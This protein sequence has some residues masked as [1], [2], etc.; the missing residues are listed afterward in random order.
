MMPPIIIFCAVPMSHGFDLTNVPVFALALAGLRFYTDHL[1]CH[2]L[3]TSKT[4]FAD[5]FYHDL[6]CIAFDREHPH[7]SDATVEAVHNV[8]DQHIRYHASPAATAG[9][10]G[11]SWLAWAGGENRLGSLLV[12]LSG[13]PEALAT[14]ALR[15]AFYC[16]DDALSH[17]LTQAVIDAASDDADTRL[18]LVSAIV[19]CWAV[20]GPHL[21]QYQTAMERAIGALCF[22]QQP[23]R[24][25]IA[26]LTTGLCYDGKPLACFIPLIQFMDHLDLMAECWP[27]DIDPVG[28]LE[29]LAIFKCPEIST[30]VTAQATA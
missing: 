14:V 4:S 30:E 28:N 2:R 3:E 13:K 6:D 27:S 16:P 17:I 19:G 25:I 29:A 18:Q 1:H 11:A 24:D 10:F 9:W 12:K 5:R 20:M 8:F 23:L 26:E 7:Q 15:R 22:T 21:P